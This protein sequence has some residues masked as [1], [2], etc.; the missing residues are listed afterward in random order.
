MGKNC[1]LCEFWCAEWGP[2]VSWNSWD[3]RRTDWR[4][5]SSRGRS[6]RASLSG[7]RGP[8]RP[9]SSEEPFQT[10]FSKSPKGEVSCQFPTKKWAKIYPSLFFSYNT[11]IQFNS[12]QF[13]SKIP[14]ACTTKISQFMKY[15][16]VR[17]SPWYNTK[18]K[19]TGCQLYKKNS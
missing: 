13:I 18:I 12:I 7:T 6:R 8:S 17:E 14:N 10:K 9:C 3:R 2:R 19:C 4:T 11:I 16:Y 5:C 15:S 1:H